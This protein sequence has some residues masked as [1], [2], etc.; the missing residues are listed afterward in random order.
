M[1]ERNRINYGIR[2]GDWRRGS[3]R[4]LCRARSS[5]ALMPFFPA[6]HVNCTPH[7][8]PLFFNFFFYYSIIFSL[9]STSFLSLPISPSTLFISARVFW[10]F[11]LNKCSFQWDREFLRRDSERSPEREREIRIWTLWGC[12]RTEVTK[13]KK[14]MGRGSRRQLFNGVKSESVVWSRERQRWSLCCVFW[15]IY[16]LPVSSHAGRVE[17]VSWLV[18]IKKWLYYPWEK[19][20]SHWN[21]YYF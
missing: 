15:Y 7:L 14:K 21:G 5:K 2:Q 19:W 1:G 3:S 16:N 18:V 10:T 6:L 13:K 11:R 17:L 20:L 12:G 9:T 8:P 4:H